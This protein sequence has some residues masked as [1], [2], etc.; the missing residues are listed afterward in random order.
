MQEKETGMV[1]AGAEE[2]H[3]VRETEVETGG[4]AHLDDHND[5]SGVLRPVAR[6]VA[7]LAVAD[8]A[9]A[10]AAAATALAG[11][12][13]EVVSMRA[14]GADRMAETIAVTNA[15]GV[16]HEADFVCH[17]ESRGKDRASRSPGPR[18]KNR[19]GEPV[20]ASMMHDEMA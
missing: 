8:P 9:A 7:D 12:E 11:A 13:A 18:S 17:G 4:A 3:V 5:Q 20:N 14:M 15:H 16:D 1:Q 2:G 10:T 19:A 6:V